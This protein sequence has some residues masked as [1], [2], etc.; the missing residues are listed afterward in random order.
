MPSDTPARF[1]QTGFT[2]FQEVRSDVGVNNIASTTFTENDTLKMDFMVS[3]LARLG[4]LVTP[5]GARQVR[6][7]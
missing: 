6:S 2:A 7:Y 1:N 4:Y 3:A 5:R